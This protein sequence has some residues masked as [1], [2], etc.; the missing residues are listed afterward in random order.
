MKVIMYYN[1][2]DRNDIPVVVVGSVQQLKDFFAAQAI[3]FPD[4]AEDEHIIKL[5]EAEGNHEYVGSHFWFA[6]REVGP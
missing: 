6:S 1:E 2:N 5:L 4:D 3:T